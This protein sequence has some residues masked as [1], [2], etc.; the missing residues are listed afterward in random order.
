MLL[1]F[2]ILVAVVA[3]SRDIEFKFTADRFG[4]LIDEL[5]PVVVIYDGQHVPK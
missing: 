4:F 1:S 5:K 3:N 2:T